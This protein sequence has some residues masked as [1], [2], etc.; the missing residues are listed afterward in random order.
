VDCLHSS[1]LRY[2]SREQWNKEQGF[3]QKE[4]GKCAAATVKVHELHKTIS[5][6]KT[7]GKHARTEETRSAF[8]LYLKNIVEQLKAVHTV[9]G[10]EVDLGDVLAVKSKS[11]IDVNFAEVARDA[12]KIN[13]QEIS[14]LYKALDEDA[15]ITTDELF[16][17]A[18]TSLREIKEVLS[19]SVDT[20]K[21]SLQERRDQYEKIWVTISEAEN[22]VV[23]MEQ[24]QE[25]AK[26]GELPTL[27]PELGKEKRKTRM[28]R[29]LGR[30]KK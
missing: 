20:L 5:K 13:M 28:A 2:F 16:Q 7:R 4:E 17:T 29:F 27:D 6:F 21:T 30:F 19:V 1:S 24:I 9:F 11:F 15:K 3:L 22:V 10:K 8:I 26:A 23:S 14:K 12:T 18:K 25:K